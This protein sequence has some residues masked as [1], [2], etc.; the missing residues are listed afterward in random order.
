MLIRE[1][2]SVQNLWWY[3]HRN[4][5]IGNAS[6]RPQNMV[7]DYSHGGRSTVLDKMFGTLH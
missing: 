2:G 5:G 7:K 1:Y 6:Q 4:Y 3:I